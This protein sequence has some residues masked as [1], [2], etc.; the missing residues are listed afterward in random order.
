MSNRPPG[1]DSQ[2][3][4]QV[5]VPHRR[6]RMILHTAF[7]QKPVGNKQMPRI[8]TAPILGKGRTDHPAF[9]SEPRARR[10]QHRAD[11]AHRRAVEGGADLEDKLRRALRQQPVASLQGLCNRHMHGRGAGL[12]RHHTRRDLRGGPGSAPTPVP[13]TP[14]RP[15]VGR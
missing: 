12:Q 11:I 8:N 10:I 6:Q 1:L 7:V 4:P 13:I 3:P 14:E 9:G 5:G 15:M 2:N